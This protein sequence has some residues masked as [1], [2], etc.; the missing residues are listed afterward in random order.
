MGREYTGYVA[1][2]EPSSWAL[3]LRPTPDLAL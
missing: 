3:G 1:V 2:G